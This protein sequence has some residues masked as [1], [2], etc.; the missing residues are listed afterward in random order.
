MRPLT[1]LVKRQGRFAEPSV[2]AQP[3]TALSA[4]APCHIVIIIEGH[5][6]VSCL[7][8]MAAPFFIDSVGRVAKNSQFWFRA[9][10]V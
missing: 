7:S 3:G 4:E 6:P 1:P 5:T 2:C 10:R 8:L 9:G